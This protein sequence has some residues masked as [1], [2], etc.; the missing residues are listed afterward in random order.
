MER[1]DS[2]SLSLGFF[3]YPVS[4]IADILLPKAHLVPVGEDQLPHIEMTREI[5][6]KFNR[7]YGAVFPEP[8]ALIGKVGRL[9]GTDG[10]AKMS[11]SL[12]NCIYLGDDERVVNERVM[13]MYTDPTRLRP[14]DPGHVEG[15]PVFLYHDAFNP[16]K[17]EVAELKERYATGHVGDVEVKRKLAVAVNAMLE[18][19]RERRH[20]FQQHQDDVR[21]ILLDGT[22]REKEVAEATMYEVRTAMRLIYTD[23]LLP[24]HRSST[25]EPAAVTSAAVTSAAPPELA[26]ESKYEQA[27]ARLS[28]LRVEPIWEGYAENGQL[29][30]RVVPG[31]HVKENPLP[32]VQAEEAAL[33]L[34][35]N[36]TN[37]KTVATVRKEVRRRVKGG[38]S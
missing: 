23:K 26:P 19:I 34:A 29:A 5:T 9:V 16:N 28:Q 3:N 33:T 38:G 7:L 6:R 4:Q 37:E 17:A 35:L 10:Q 22:R 13:T 36:L 32:A 30:F 25:P 14:T 31:I 18:P 1:L 15:N 12:N 21:D 20:H 24:S 8:E 11:K 2:E 27:L